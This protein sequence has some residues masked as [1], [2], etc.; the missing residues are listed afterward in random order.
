MKGAFTRSFNKAGH[1]SHYAST[2][3]TAKRSRSQDD[4][5]WNGAEEEE[6]E[7]EN[8]D[9]ESGSDKGSSAGIDKD[10][11]IKVIKRAKGKI[12]GRD[13]RGQKNGKKK[14]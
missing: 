13:G 6:G 14:K 8:G 3:F 11:T 9:G 5:G 7:E 10:P 1:L 12:N 4:S 2:G